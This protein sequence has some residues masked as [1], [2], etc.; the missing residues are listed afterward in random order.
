MLVLWASQTGNA[1]G[2][3]A[4][5]AKR[6]GAGGQPV[7]LLAMEAASPADLA[8]VPFALLVTSTFGDG[9]PPDNGSG[10][11]T[12]LCAEAAPRLTDLRYA[13]LGFGD[14]SY[15]QFCGFARKLDARLEALGGTRLAARTDCEPDFEETAGTWLDTVAAAL[16]EPDGGKEGPAEAGDIL[17]APPAVVAPAAKAA[18]SAFTRKAPLRTRLARNILLSGM[19]AQKEVRQFG[20][21][22]AG[23]DFVYQ[24]GDALGV[25][26]VNCPD[27][28]AEILGV[29][30]CRAMPRSRSRKQA[31]LHSPT[32]CRGI[33]TSPA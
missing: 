19:G 4:D 22:I 16:S 28:V 31:R 11:W 6:L 27:L 32:G 1:E 29:L 8:G 25:W 13:V 3:A 12:A 33:G 30:S 2:F 24:A 9:D 18:P 26:P 7:R 15:D 5:C 10:F 17:I 14:S 21:D 23:H 20:F